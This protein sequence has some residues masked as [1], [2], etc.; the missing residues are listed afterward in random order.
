M[1]LLIGALSPL[2]A[3]PIQ[4]S[5]GVGGN[6]HYYELVDTGGFVAWLDAQ[7]AAQAAGGYLATI[8]SAEENSF[9]ALLTGGLESYIGAH[10]QN[11]EGAF[12][13]VTGEAFGFTNWAFNEPNDHVAPASPTGEDFVIINPPANPLGTWND[14]PNNP[15]RVTAYVVEYDTQPVPEPSTLIL[16][17]GALM[18]FAIWRIG[19][20]CG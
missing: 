12:E 4:W 7:A 5:S 3:A 16:L 8:T 11:T 19:R 10:D 9:I 2:G 6:D 14:L 20:R 18:P 15:F 1:F 13:W 17:G